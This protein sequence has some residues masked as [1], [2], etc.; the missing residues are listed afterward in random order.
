MQNNRDEYTGPLFPS[1]EF[2]TYGAAFRVASTNY[3]HNQR[4]AW[5]E[6]KS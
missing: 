4:I 3:S 5:F 6:I 2:A 1:G